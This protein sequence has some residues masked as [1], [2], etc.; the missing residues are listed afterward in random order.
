[1]E[2]NILFKILQNI[3]SFSD[4]SLITRKV[5]HKMSHTYHDILY[6]YFPAEIFHWIAQ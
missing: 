3:S 5:R 4:S 6:T 2:M 1:M